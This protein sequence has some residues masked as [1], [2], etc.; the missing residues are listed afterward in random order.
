M[1]LELPGHTAENK[2]LY[3]LSWLAVQLTA[4]PPSADVIAIHPPLF[5]SQTILATNL[6]ALCGAE[7][8]VEGFPFL[9]SV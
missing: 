5:P 2:P 4:M 9:C 3:A 7:D 1:A 6:V 8:G